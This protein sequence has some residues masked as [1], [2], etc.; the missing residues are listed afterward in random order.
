MSGRGAL[1]STVLR[2]DLLYLIRLLALEQDTQ[3][4]EAVLAALEGAGLSRVQI[5]ERLSELM[6]ERDAL[7]Q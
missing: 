1:A 7:D 4:A 6:A 2:E 3:S 5:S